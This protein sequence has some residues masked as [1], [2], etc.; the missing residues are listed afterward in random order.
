MKNN[1][2]DHTRIRIP[3]NYVLVLPDKNFTTY[4]FQ[5]RETGIEVGISAV[6]DLTDDDTGIERI[7]ETVQTYAHHLSVKGKVYAIPEKLIYNGHKIK[8]ARLNFSNDNSSMQKL[9]GLM[10]ES[11]D[12][13]TLMEVEVGDEVV[14]DYRSHLECYEDGKFIETELGDMFLIRYDMLQIAINPYGEKKALNG[15]VFLEQKL[16]EKET[17][18]GLIIPVLSGKEDKIERWDI[19]EV[20]L[21]GNP[22]F[23]YKDNIEYSDDP[24]PISA[25]DFIM[26]RPGG[27]GLLENDLHQIIFP[28]KR[29]LTVR[30]R[31]IFMVLPNNQN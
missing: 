18:S 15:L 20:V 7:E 10:S 28:G 14:F 17:P 29:I 26:Y 31:D 21:S 22:V 3:S 23:G 13:D 9:G 6:R 25:G 5:G 24:T 30:R 11:L 8:Y 12:F 19:G 2:V 4:Q 16:Y 27:T 1:I